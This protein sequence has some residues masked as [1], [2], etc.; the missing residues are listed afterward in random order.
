M[1][2]FFPG[3]TFMWRTLTMGLGIT[4]QFRC[5]GLKSHRL[6]IKTALNAFPLAAVSPIILSIASSGAFTYSSKVSFLFPV[7]C[8][9]ITAI[10]KALGV[11]WPDFVSLMIGG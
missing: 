7:P 2:L 3:P 8:G 9:K 5:L 11:Y 6:L 4:E 10:Y 1:G